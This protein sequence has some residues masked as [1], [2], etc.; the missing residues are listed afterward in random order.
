MSPPD[1]A[2]AASLDGDA[3][4]N[5]LTILAALGIDTPR[6]VLHVT[7]IGRLGHGRLESAPA[8]A[9]GPCGVSPG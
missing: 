6:T 7:Y 3:A 2:S 1:L 5:P 9:G 4:L 8:R